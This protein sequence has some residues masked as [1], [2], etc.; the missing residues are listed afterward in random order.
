[1]KHIGNSNSGTI[2]EFSKEELGK[3]RDVFGRPDYDDYNGIQTIDNLINLSYAIFKDLG[4]FKRL[5]GFT[6]EKLTR[7]SEL[8]EKKEFPLER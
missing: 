3:L 6:S 1:M 7:L 8:V 4:D 2:I 5:V